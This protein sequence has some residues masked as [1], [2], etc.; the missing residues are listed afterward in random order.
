MSDGRGDERGRTGGPVAGEAAA[1]PP[2]PAGVELRPDEALASHTYL[3]LG[4][5][6]R[7]YAE[8]VDREQLGLLLAW[9]ATAALPV[10]VLGGGSNLLVADEGWPGLV[11]SLRRCCG[12]VA[13][14][15]PSVCAGAAVMLPALARA[16][17]KR[18][19]GGLE[20]A[21]GIPGS[22]GGALQ[23]NAGIGDGRS[24]GS[25]VRAVELWRD[26][27]ATTVEATSV[28]FDYRET[29]LR[30]SGALVLGA[31]LALEPRPRADVEAEMRRLLRA[32]QA[33]QPTAERNAGSIFRNPPGEAAGRLIEAAGC[34]GLVVGG[35][36]VSELHANFIVHDGAA[37]AADVAALMAKVQRRVLAHAGMRLVPEIE[38]WGPGDPPE[39]F[40][41]PSAPAPRPSTAPG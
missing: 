8:P 19:L 26:G 6:A 12:E 9:A 5:P 16:A 14:D 11:L 22:L 29:S 33:T 38:W 32:R 35:A 15:G 4:G 2:A 3:R 7:F 20:F 40:A 23:S 13:F 41:P 17:A 37:R 34:K 30:G 31:T 36:R 1:L 10:R 21:I 28:R 39:A 25:L 18:D 27:A 24:I